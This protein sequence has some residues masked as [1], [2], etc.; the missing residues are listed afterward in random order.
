MIRFLFSK[1]YHFNFTVK[2]S[3]IAFASAGLGY[4]VDDKRCDQ[5]LS[6]S[7][8]TAYHAVLHGRAAKGNDAD[9]KRL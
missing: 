1:C 7:L 8:K 5:E 9:V 3:Q 6:L 2:L 4:R